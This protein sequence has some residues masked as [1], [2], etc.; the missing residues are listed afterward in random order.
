[1]S[2]CVEQHTSQTYGTFL[3]FLHLWFVG[4]LKHSLQRAGPVLLATEGM[5]LIAA[6]GMPMADEEEDK[7][8]EPSFRDVLCF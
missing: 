8:T 5:P 1:M 4:M 3:H 7:D 2:G 6:L